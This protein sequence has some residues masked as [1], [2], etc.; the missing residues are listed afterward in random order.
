[1]LVEQK[2]PRIHSANHGDQIES[3]VTIPCAIAALSRMEEAV[4]ILF[5]KTMEARWWIYPPELTFTVS[6]I[7]EELV[8]RKRPRARSMPAANHES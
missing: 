3:I 7:E 1:M 6:G 8:G 2:A 5:D 4:I